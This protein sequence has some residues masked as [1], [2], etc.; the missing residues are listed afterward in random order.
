M[1]WDEPWLLAL[2]PPTLVAL[3]WFARGSVQPL[4]AR[5]R[6]WLTIVRMALAVLAIVALAGPTLTL[7]AR[8]HA[9]VVVADHSHSQGADGMARA[10]AAATAALGDVPRATRIGVVSAGDEPAVRLVPE[11]GASLPPPAAAGTQDGGAQ[12]DL[13]AALRVACGLFPPHSARRVLLVGDGVETRGDLMAAARE[14]AAAGVVIDCLPVAGAVRP[15]ARVA[16]M[17]TSHVRAHEGAAIAIVADLES[18]Y[19]ASGRVRLFENGVEVDARALTLAAGEIATAT[20]RRTPTQ[21]NLYTY[22]VELDGFAG[23]EVRSNDEGLAL[24]EVRGR[25]I[26][27]YIDGEPDEAHVLADAMAQEGIDLVVRPPEAMPRELRELAGYD[28]IILSDLPAAAL[29][30]EAFAALRAYVE[31]LGGGFLM[32]GGPNAFGAGGWYR[33]PIEDI[34]PVKLKAPDTEERAPTALM[35]VVDRSGSMDGQK[36]QMCKE[37]AAATAELLE[38]KDFL[39]VV[40]FDSSAHWVVPMGRLGDRSGALSRIRAIDCGG[41]TNIQPGMEAGR[42]AIRGVAARRRHMIVMTDGISQGGGYEAM[43]ATLRAQGVTVSTVAVGADADGALLARMAASGGGKFHLARD[44]RQL[45]RVFTQ[46]AMTH[47]GKLVREQPFA[48]RQVERHIMLTGIDLA[49]APQL[50]GYVRTHRRAAAQVPL[51]TDVGDPLLAHWRF[52]LGKVTAFTGDCKGR[53]SSLWLGAWQAGYQ[54]FWAQ[55]LRE[56]ARPPQGRAI[57]LRLGEEDGRA[58]IV[59]D[60]LDGA[61]AFKD[62][63]EI[64][65]EVFHVGVSSPGGAMRPLA[66]PLLEQTGPGRYVG[67]FAPD[68]AGVYLVRAQSG[69]D[70]AT[71]G[72]VHQPGGESATGRVDRRLLERIAAIT[73][74]RVLAEG[75]RVAM[76]DEPRG[77]AVPLR[78]ALTIALLLLFLVDLVIRR[79]ENCLGVWER[80]RG[81]AARGG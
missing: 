31:Q 6:R 27:L 36:L 20:F 9:L 65:C 23:D 57:D 56:V 37:A 49:S 10:H 46:D 21:R 14:A 38:A 34:L 44:P 59:V 1:T 18:S 81:S 3:A 40:A 16:A 72:L 79:W 76:H 51:V 47:L 35:L 2:I 41:G 33:T 19:A 77:A 8:A 42:D 62:G 61:A 60:V 28:G 11:A 52:G 15:D 24:V 80:L 48:P 12:S 63:A 54:Q 13:A 68:R 78:T 39:G 43:A 74:G 17:R 32:I 26:L 25:P 69:A 4:R 30:D 5:R 29:D 70:I 75:E 55:V 66:P 73:G 64:A 7:P 58:R 22:R 67:A 71:A 45:P 53:W 50:L